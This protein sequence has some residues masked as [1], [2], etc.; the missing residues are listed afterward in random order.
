MAQNAVAHIIEVGSVRAREQETILGLAGMAQNAA[1]QQDHVGAHQSAMPHQDP[2]AN[3]GRTLHES[4][5]L[6]SRPFANINGIFTEMGAGHYFAQEG[7]SSLGEPPH[8][9]ADMRHSLPGESA[10]GKKGS[11]KWVAQIKEIRRMKQ[12]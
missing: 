1:A 4:A 3:I 12:F 10:V 11:D 9:L 6:D 2:L 5:R 8:V 7:L